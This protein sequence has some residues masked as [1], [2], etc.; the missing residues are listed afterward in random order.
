MFESIIITLGVFLGMIVLID[1]AFLS[2]KRHM[3]HVTKHQPPRWIQWAYDFFP[4][5]LFVIFFRAFL[6]E[7]FRIPSG[8]LKPNVLPGDFILVSKFDYGLRSPLTNQTLI[9]RDH[10][11]K[12]GDVVVFQYPEDLSK[13]FIKRI[14]GLPGD[15]IDYVQKQ[16]YI[17]GIPI[18]QTHLGHQFD[19]F[20][21]KRFELQKECIDSLS[22]KNWTPITSSAQKIC[23]HIQTDPEQTSA[24]I[25]DLIVPPHEFFVLG[26]NR[27]NSRDSRYWGFVHEK[28]LKGKARF[29]FFHLSDGR[30][31]FSR[32][33]KAIH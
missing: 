13:N 2:P 15:H 4:V 32:I 31:D 20:S 17:N 23:Y 26:D 30:I 27:D 19:F 16:I 6:F 11:P 8:S 1:L 7:P 3:L 21:Q 22:L 18:S 9:N 28:N 5:I 24:D 14:I 29:V 12:R 10:Q 33:G 25:Y